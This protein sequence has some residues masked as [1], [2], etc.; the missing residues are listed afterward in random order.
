MTCSTHLLLSSGDCVGV[1]APASHLPRADEGYLK[2]GI[3]IV[4]GMGFEVRYSPKLLA[5]R[6]LYFAG[7]DEE[8]G[9]EL[10]SMFRDPDVKGILCARGGYGAQ[11]V[12]PYLDP[13]TIRR[14]P[15]PLVGC[16]DITVL[17]IY[18]WR[19]CFTPIFHGPNIATR[20]FVQ[21]GEEMHNALKNA[22]IQGLAHDRIPCHPLRK[23]EAEGELIGGCLSSLVTT[24]G[25]DYEPELSGRILF[26]EDVNEPPYRIDRMLTHLGS[27]G[28]LDGVKGVIFGQ[29]PGCD[30]D[31]GLL[32]D[33]ILD[34]LSPFKGPILIGFPSGHGERNITIPLGHPV[35]I[36]DGLVYFGR[37]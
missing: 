35:V 27:A 10:M 30:M 20:Q 18:L 36:S 4:K 23:G 22:L 34:A 24:I 33:A 7:R 16:S 15:K 29:M 21:G 25:T 11:R 28:L 5:R 6:H 2:Q 31:D 17:L 13:D 9:H 32:A 12:I 14:H 8:R 26:L 1:V 37:R 19:C 3:E